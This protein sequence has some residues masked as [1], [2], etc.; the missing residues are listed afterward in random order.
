MIGHAELKPIIYVSR[1]IVSKII[2]KGLTWIT[3]H[4]TRVGSISCCLY[5]LLKPS[6]T[7]QSQSQV[8][9]SICNEQLQFRHPN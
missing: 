5:F 4:M 7:S 1:K 2:L 6:A 9:K 3:K 8:F